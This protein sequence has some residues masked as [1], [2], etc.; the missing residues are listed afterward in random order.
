MRQ[1]IPNILT[2]SNLFCGVLALLMTWEGNLTVVAALLVAA[3]TFDFFDGF[4]ARALKV[5]SPVGKELDSLAD[6]VSFGVVPGM[7]MARLIRESGGDAFPEAAMWTPGADWIWI[8]G[9]LVPVFSALRLARFNLDTR[10]S[11]TFFGLPTPSNT[12]F[13]LG[14]WFLID[15]NR[16][17]FADVMNPWVLSGITLLFC[18]LLIADVRLL[19]LK[20]H[21]Y[22]FQENGFRY[23]LIV[24]SIVFIGLLGP[25]GLSFIILYYLALSI[26]HNLRDTR[27]PAG[28]TR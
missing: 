22:H 9:L 20:F 16:W 8:V 6:M 2:A 14:L 28:R 26:I 17:G 27:H 5:D 15:Q 13:I 10:Q 19:A 24:G 25:G 23:F 4:V 21:H 12:I 3:L 7:I 11:D 18:W 1:S